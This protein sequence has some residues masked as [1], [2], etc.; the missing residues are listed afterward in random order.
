MFSSFILEES[1]RENLLYFKKVKSSW[2]SWMRTSQN[3]DIYLSVFLGCTV[4]FHINRPP[5]IS[6]KLEIFDVLPG[7]GFYYILTV[8]DLLSVKR[9]CQKGD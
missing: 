5:L 4:F 3:S 7:A 6:V 9:L 8:L 2:S 1:S